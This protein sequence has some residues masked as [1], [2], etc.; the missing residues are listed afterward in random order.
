MGCGVGSGV[1]SAVGFGV[2]SGVGCRVGS[3]VGCGVG[4]RVGI[5]VGDGVGW[6]VGFGVSA[7]CRACACFFR[8]ANTGSKIPMQI[9]WYLQ[10]HSCLASD[11]T[12]RQFDWP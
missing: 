10:H 8:A 4:S 9:L 6:L 1:G 11:H 2:G 5:G 12:I 3:K 7:S